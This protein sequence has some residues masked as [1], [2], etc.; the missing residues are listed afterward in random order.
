MKVALFDYGAGNLH[1]L[2]KA[3][4]AAGTSVRITAD[5]DEALASGRARAA[6]G[7]R[8]RRGRRGAAARPVTG[9]R[10]PGG[11][12][13]PVWASAWA[14][15]SSSRTARSREGAGIGLIPGQGAPA[16]RPGSSPRWGGTTSR[17]PP[18]R[19]SRAPG[20]LVA[21][22]ANSYVCEPE[23]PSDAIAWCEYEGARFASAV[24]RGRTWG[25]QFHPE[26]SSAP[27]RRLLENW[28]AL[29]RRQSCGERE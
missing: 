25:V 4:E 16:A 20:A 13:C 14:C 15:S 7:G 28:V 27:G 9:A 8:V 3:L 17:R 12:T 19:S 2:A 1:S 11:G 6:W 22:Y 23:D 18:T 21:Y 24:R 26:K 5:W 10:G 29:A